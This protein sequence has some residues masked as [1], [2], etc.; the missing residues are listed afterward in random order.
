VFLPTKLLVIKNDI[1]HQ[2]KTYKNHFKFLRY[3][4]LVTLVM[5]HTIS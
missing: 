3:V 1:L 4:T 5:W 2:S